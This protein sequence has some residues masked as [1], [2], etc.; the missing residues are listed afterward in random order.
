MIYRFGPFELDEA[1][2]ELRRGGEPVS[3]Q[4]KPLA[5]L[6]LLVRERARIVSQDE[7]FEALW[8]GTVVTP[9][10]LTRAVSHARKAVGDTHKGSLLRSV[11]RRGYRFVGDVEELGGPAAAPAAPE[12]PPAPAP[13]PAGGTPGDLFVG[14]DD[15]LAR[16]REGW[17]RARGG[18]GQIVL[19]A[20]AA[21]IGK[22]RLA[23]VFARELASQGHLVV[24]GR[25]RDGDGVPAFWLWT[26]V[27]RALSEAELVDAGEWESLLSDAG[28]ASDPE[29]RFLFFDSVSRA[30]TAAA[31][32]RPLAIVLEDLQWARKASLRLLEHLSFE[33][34]A[35]R[36]LLLGSIRSELRERGH[37][38]SRCVSTLAKHGFTEQVELGG[39]SR[40][41]VAALL[42]GAIGRAA[43]AELTSEIYARTEGVPL[44]VREAVR[45]LQERG[46]LRRPERI[47]RRG[48]TLP[49]HAVDLIRRSLEAL[50]DDCAAVV[51]A[52]AVLGREFG[53]AAVAAVAD[54][55]RSDAMDVLDEAVVAGVLE[56]VPGAASTYR[57]THALFQ[58]SAYED[59]QRGQRSRL[60]ALAAARLESQ[61]AGDLSPVMA[62]LANHCHRSIAVVD[63][64]RAWEYAI[65]AARQALRQFAYEQAARHFEQALEAIEHLEI[66]DPERRVSALIEMGEAHRLAGDRQRRREVSAQAM[67]SARALGWK[68]TFA[69]AAIRFC[70]ITEWSPEDD[71]ANAVVAEALD[72]LAEEE[73]DLRARLTARVAYLSVRDRSSRDRALEAVGL[74]RETKDP[75]TLQEALYVRLYS[76]A[77]P[78]HLDE[79]REIID[80]LCDAVRAASHREPTLI[81]LLDVACDGL[82]LGDPALATRMRDRAA[83]LCG[84]APSQGMV[85]H[86]GVFDTGLAL[87]EGRIEDVEQ[88]TSDALLV[89]RRLDHPYAQACF[90]AQRMQLYR[91]Q[92]DYRAIRPLFAKA[93]HSKL[94]ANH[95]AI[96][97]LARTDLQLGNDE[98]ARELWE[99]LAARDFDQIERGIRWIGTVLELAHLCADLDDGPRAESLIRLLAPAED[100]HGVLPVPI[101]YGGPASYALAR[102][103]EVIGLVDAAKQYYEHALDAAARLGARPMQARIQQDFAALIGPRGDRERARTLIEEADG[104]REETGCRL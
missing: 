83:E 102:L 13:E 57:F 46:D 76:V 37:P 19:V 82:T 86:T 56:E 45:L 9:G 104:I 28:D 34:G 24:F 80:E 3:V 18:E 26:Q 96:A 51:A 101:L 14:R 72:G 31:R 81:A 89:G 71:T 66:V 16:L 90:N 78:D 39:L 21:G 68:R 77:G 4:P 59:L 84:D 100:L 64:E 8:P 32:K 44:F 6:M 5:L 29:Q 67:E 63:P 48:V 58:E 35:S 52:G 11:S 47:R 62:E 49:A 95:W 36:L 87:L 73:L 33:M 99:G 43:P 53:L 79:R 23:E 40:R 38:L 60:H 20:G 103:N 55:D 15:A 74:A 27:L 7:L 93:A 22:T 12:A 85:W 94:G 1:A 98:S 61:H 17:S 88:A 2:G 92:H 42:A 75:D 41:D 69:E 10:S 25:C 54:L 65:T 91:Y 30:L 97:V 50:S 70:D